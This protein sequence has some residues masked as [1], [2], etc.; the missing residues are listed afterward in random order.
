M[1][2][3]RA[4]FRRLITRYAAGMLWAASWLTCPAQAANVSWVGIVNGD[5]E[6]GTGGF[7]GESGGNGQSCTT[8]GPGFGE[9]GSFFGT[10]VG[11]PLGGIQ[12]C[13]YFGGSLPASGAPVSASITAQINGGA[14]SAGSASATASLAAGAAGAMTGDFTLHAVA[15]QTLANASSSPT[16]IFQSAAAALADDPA[17][18]V[19]APGLTPGTPLIPTY[20]WAVSANAGSP[21]LSGAP[22]VAFGE[23]DVAIY[24]QQIGTDVNALP[25]FGV[26]ISYGQ[27]PVV[28]FYNSNPVNSCSAIGFTTGTGTIQGTGTFTYT[29]PG[30]IPEGETVEEEVGLD[31]IA[32][33]NAYVDPDATLVGVSFAVNTVLGAVPLTNFTLTTSGGTFTQNGFTANAAAAPEPFTGLLAAVGILAVGLL[34]GTSGRGRSFAVS[35]PESRTE[36]GRRQERDEPHAT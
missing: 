18:V 28:C 33:G 11:I 16:T 36:G 30:T 9:P 4:Q 19:T 22:N 32:S 21:Y 34:T 5:G 27:N 3:R 14:S 6:G 15:N 13:G 8:Y 31:A 29:P 2:N 1:T 12:P 7:F 35:S 25:A 20:T 24:M 10:I 23:A 26:R 17:W